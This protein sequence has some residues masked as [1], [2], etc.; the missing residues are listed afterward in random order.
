MLRL[1]RV[2]LRRRR[3]VWLSLYVLDR[4]LS[5]SLGRTLAIND[6]D[7]D[8]AAPENGSAEYEDLAGF[9]ALVALHRL[10]GEIVAMTNS[11]GMVKALRDAAGLQ[12]LR[13]KVEALNVRLRS[14]ATDIVP[15]HVR[16]ATTGRLLTQ[17]CVLLSVYFAAIMALHRPLMATPHRSSPLGA[18][19]IA[20]QCARAAINCIHSTSS[21][22]ASIPKGLF[23]A[24]HGQQVLVASVLLMHCLRLAKDELS[25]S[26]ALRYVDISKQ[27]L[28]DLEPS[29]AG[30]RKGR[31]IVEAFLEFTM[32]VLESGKTGVCHFSHAQDTEPPLAGDSKPMRNPNSQCMNCASMSTVPGSSRPKKRKL[33]TSEEQQLFGAEFARPS[34]EVFRQDDTTSTLLSP[35]SAASYNFVAPFSQSL[36]QEST[37]ELPSLYSSN[38]TE[39]WMNFSFPDLGPKDPS[40]FESPHVQLGSIRPNGDDSWDVF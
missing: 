6:L 17:R 19:A 27:M 22:L 15:P 40:M 13:D 24:F 7:C 8:V 2:E 25:A 32:Q 18:S 16:N 36:A 33:A 21:H 31:A 9:F 3:C 5:I 35:P 39:D 34:Q 20:T 37:T 1:P 4:S 23:L 28:Q 30:A 12:E 29:W 11:V 26:D 38:D 14:W 10:S